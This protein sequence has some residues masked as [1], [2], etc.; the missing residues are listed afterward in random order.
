ML[1][2]F[3]NGGFNTLVSSHL[4]VVFLWLTQEKKGLFSECSYYW[5]MLAHEEIDYALW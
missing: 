2:V 5:A 1:G 3:L 4:S